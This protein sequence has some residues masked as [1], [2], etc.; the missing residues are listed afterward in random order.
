MKNEYM[1]KFFERFDELK[2]RYPDLY[3]QIKEFS[4]APRR[5]R[6]HVFGKSFSPLGDTEFVFA[7]AADREDAFKEALD[8]MR[9]IEEKIRNLEEMQIYG[10]RVHPNHN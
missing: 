10:T 6:V 3:L 5:W 7:E 8:R 2:S 9:S 1:I 4:R